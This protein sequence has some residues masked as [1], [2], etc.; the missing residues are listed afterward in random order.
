MGNH[1]HLLVR[2]NAGRLSEAMRHLSTTYVRH[3]NDRV[4]RDGPLFRGRYRSKIVASDAYLS[5]VTRYI[6]R[7][8][9]PIVDGE[10]LDRYRWSS[11]PA[12]L[13]RRPRP[14]FLDAEPVL[15]MFHH[16]AVEFEEFTTGDTVE[17]SDWRLDDLRDVV[18]LAIVEDERAFDAEAHH[19]QLARTI[20]TLVADLLPLPAFDPAGCAVAAGTS[21]SAWERAVRRARSRASDPEVIRIVARVLAH[22]DAG[23][24]MGSGTFWRSAGSAL[25]PAGQKVPDPI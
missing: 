16:D 3:L 4:G 19:G 6:H 1:Y 13:G 10:P 22:L 23:G 25:R 12:Y 15:T 11:Y 17:I 18:D 2:S 21:R 8:P 20:V 14:L 9:L 5:W 7:N 24:Q